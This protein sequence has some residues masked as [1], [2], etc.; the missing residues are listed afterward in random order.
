MRMYASADVTDGAS[1]DLL[2]DNPDEYAEIIE[3]NFGMPYESG[4]IKEPRACPWG[5]IKKF[6]K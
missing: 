5:S 2:A 4:Y 6:K 3:E 1:L